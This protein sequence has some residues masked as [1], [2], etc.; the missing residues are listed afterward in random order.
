MEN[1]RSLL[2]ILGMTNLGMTL[3]GEKGTKSPVNLRWTWVRFWTVNT[4]RHVSSSSKSPD[5]IVAHRSDRS[6][7]A[8]PISLVLRSWICG[9]TKEPSGF[10]VNHRKPHELGVAS[11]NHHSWLGSHIVLAGP[12]FWGSTK[13]P[14]MTSSCCFCHHAACTRPRW[15]P[16]PSNQANLSSPH[17][18]DSPATTFALVIHLY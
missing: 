11:A 6:G 1:P 3:L 17:L 12:W 8:A 16:G 15:P 5:C 7:A 2:L 10:L 18:E 9:S 14:S 13:K 4:S